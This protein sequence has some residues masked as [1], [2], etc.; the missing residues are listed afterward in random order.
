[1]DSSLSRLHQ[2]VV[3]ACSGT[4]AAVVLSRPHPNLFNVFRLKIRQFVQLSSSQLSPLPSPTV[5]ATRFLGNSLGPCARAAIR[6][7]V[8]LP[9][10]QE[11]NSPAHLNT[12]T[13]TTDTATLKPQTPTPTNV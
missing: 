10:A 8:L 13:I 12:T 6:H 3:S 11:P 1:R 5:T 4:F 2:S 7:D 9:P